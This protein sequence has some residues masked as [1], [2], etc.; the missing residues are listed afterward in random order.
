[1]PRLKGP[2]EKNTGKRNTQGHSHLIQVGVQ[3]YGFAMSEL[4][5]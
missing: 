5:V 3:S 2:F 1:M 4:G